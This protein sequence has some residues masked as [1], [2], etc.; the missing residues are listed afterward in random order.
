MSFLIFIWFISLLGTTFFY[1]RVKIDN[2]PCEE[3]QKTAARALIAAIIL[4]V[5]FPIIIWVMGR[6]LIREA[7]PKEKK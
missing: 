6:T 1:L 2:Y 5:S 4:P 7:F 3:T